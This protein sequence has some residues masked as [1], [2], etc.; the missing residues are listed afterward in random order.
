MGGSGG[1]VHRLP[2]LILQLQLP[3]G[4]EG[5]S[6]TKTTS[7]P[8]EPAAAGPQETVQHTTEG[9]QMNYKVLFKKT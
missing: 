9:E 4:Q 2:R 8:G 1:P 6:G 7:P 3:E 5:T